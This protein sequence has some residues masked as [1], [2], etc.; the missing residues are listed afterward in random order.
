[1]T[2]DSEERPQEKT[3]RKAL[4]PYQITVSG[5]ISIAGLLAS[6]AA[7]YNAIQNDIV[8][9][10]RDVVHQERTSERLSDD[11][12][13]VR[14]ET[15]SARSEQRETMREFSDKLD[16]IFERVLQRRK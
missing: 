9:L 5:I 4:S 3:Q 1:M 16:H 14:E 7:T 6:G 13:A 11:I 15:R 10:K 2:C 8:A 12:K